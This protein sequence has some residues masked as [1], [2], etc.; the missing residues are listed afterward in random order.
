MA[1]TLGDPAF[2]GRRAELARLA[3]AL[4]RAKG[5]DAG[6]VLL[7]GEA[8]VGKTRLVGEFV[9]AAAAAGAQV[10]RG[11]CIEL[12]EAS[13][14]YAPVVEAL[15]GL[16]RRTPRARLDALL[17]SGRGQLARLLPE[18]GPADPSPAGGDPLD[19]AQLALFERLL[20]LLVRLGE[21]A[22][23]VLV[24][25]DLHWS[26]RSSRDLLAFLVHSLADARV[27]VVATFRTDELRRTHP[28]RPFLAQLE[29]DDRVERLDLTPFDRVELAEFLVALLGEPP[30]ADLA[31]EVFERSQGN[32]FFAEEL[33]ASAAAGA[34]RPGELPATLRDALLARVD[35][36]PAPAPA[37]PRPAAAAGEEVDHEL[38]AAVAGMDAPD[39]LAA[40]R[41]A[42][43][44]QVLVAQP[45]RLTYR[46]RHALL[47]EAVHGDLL[48]GERVDLHRRLAQVLEERPEL[49]GSRAGAAA[50]LAW[51]WRRAHDLPRALAAAVTAGQD[52]ATAYAFAD[53]HV[54]YE[55][56]L[57]LWDA[58]PEA[59]RP[60]GTDRVELLKRAATA[61]ARSGEHARAVALARRALDQLDEVAEPV[62]A[63]LLWM[64]LARSLSALGDEAAAHATA[65][66]VRLVPDD[67]SPA[68]ARVLGY[69]SARLMLL[70]RY[71]E[72]EPVGAEAVAVARAV[73]AHADEAGA[74][75]TLGLCAAFL[76]RQAEGEALLARARAIAL[77]AGAVPELER[78]AANLPEVLQLDGRWEEAARAALEGVAL[79]AEHGYGKGA[80][81]R[82][83]AVQ[84]L[85]KLGRWDEAEGLLREALA[86]HGRDN[87]GLHVLHMRAV[88][89]LWRGRLDEAAAT[90]DRALRI[91]RTSAFGPQYVADLHAT[92]AALRLGQGRLDEADAAV[93]AALASTATAGGR[94]FHGAPAVWTGV[95][96]EVERAR[97]P[98]PTAPPRART[99]CSRASRTWW[100]APAWRPPRSSRRCWGPRG[101]SARACRTATRP[102]RPRP[103]RAPSPPG[104]AWATRTAPVSRGSGW[105]PRCSP[106]A[107]GTTARARPPRCGP[108][109]R[110]RSGW[111]PPRWPRRR[112][113]RRGAVGST[114][115]AGAPPRTRTA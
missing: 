54:Q 15:R 30:P 74:L 87:Q 19:G 109:R 71:A 58:V 57:E 75:V 82:G 114:W 39:L 22:P 63:S 29:R 95:A 103:G 45:D 28:L 7:G 65:E 53:A 97:A 100:R 73:G 55:A 112:R 77:A 4:D 25:E 107:A 111:A 115:T 79:V 21:D 43:A 70:S 11:G 35:A 38:L 72:S 44:E 24:L 61:A 27:L 83:N 6:A 23:L 67:P 47:Q 32:A 92:L 62:R 105:R 33:A 1:R 84:V 85:L 88:L 12:G 86:I 31:D 64:W 108:P 78:V 113:G 106:T 51:H 48:P 50:A 99:R 8:G 91:G 76:G 2:V 36:L 10:L 41:T 42:V 3:G 40:L 34:G 59:Q 94:P 16:A 26:D 93:R 60:P 13:L 68:R 96:I 104:T 81:I 37:A 5:G 9:R 80:F 98:T 14:P 46:F 90:L 101:P 102:R 89:H 110:S 20:S 18:L 17:G 49:A 52:A 66:A 56:A 69:Q